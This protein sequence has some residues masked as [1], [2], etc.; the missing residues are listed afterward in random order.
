MNFTA[1]DFMI[2]EG[3]D[4][5][6]ELRIIAEYVGDLLRTDDPHRIRTATLAVLR[7]VVEENLVEVGTLNLATGELDTWTCG[8]Q[9]AIDRITHEW[10]PLA[11]P[12]E[13]YEI[14][15]F[16]DT[17]RGKEIAAQLVSNMRE[18]SS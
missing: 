11:G 15:C 8:H 14:A 18:N 5:F 4:D 7:E 3:K 6:V 9:E 13:L 17:I 1:K 10:R 2:I 16:R 12:L